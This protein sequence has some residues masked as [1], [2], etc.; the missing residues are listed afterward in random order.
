MK[1][2]DAVRAAAEAI[3]QMPQI[4]SLVWWSVSE[5]T[6]TREDLKA[7]FEAQGIP[8]NFLIDTR[9]RSAFKKALK[10][11]EKDKLVRKIDDS[12][13]RIVY[14]IVTETADKKALDLDYST[15]GVVIYD[16]QTRTLSFKVPP[17]REAEIKEAFK[18]YLFGYTSREVRE[19]IRKYIM[20]GCGGFLAREGG[21][22]YFIPDERKQDLLKIERAIASMNGGAS[23]V[24]IMGIP[25]A[26]REKANAL[27]LWIEE[28]NRQ[29]KDMERDVKKL[30]SSGTAKA[31]T[32]HSRLEAFKALRAK[33][34]MYASALGFEKDSIED[35]V[36]ALEG[37]VLVALTEVESK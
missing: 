11:A 19:I 35:K 12:P 29:L 8:E 2:N 15:E 6:I 18:K 4:G 24:F 22:V 37:T 31:A 7:L 33:A 10:E 5:T 3:E 9:A 28:V 36:K 21:G 27:R 20:D 14:G 13:E 16:K 1:T 30:T 17:A 34:Q 25:D 26:E 32:L 23:H